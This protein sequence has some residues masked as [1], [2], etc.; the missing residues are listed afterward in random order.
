MLQN[1]PVQIGLR[2]ALEYD[3]EYCRRLYF[4]EMRWIVDELR[5]DR[6]AQETS[7]VRKYSVGPLNPLKMRGSQPPPSGQDLTR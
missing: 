3:F 5:L 1:R 7:V 4:A 6:N 2:P